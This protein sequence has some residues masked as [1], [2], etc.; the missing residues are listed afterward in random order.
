MV[1]VLWEPEIGKSRKQTQ[2]AH[3]CT[4]ALICYCNTQ[5]FWVLNFQEPNK[6]I[7]QQYKAEKEKL[8][9]IRLLLVSYSLCPYLCRIADVCLI[10]ELLIL[11]LVVL[12]LTI[13][14]V[15]NQLQKK[16]I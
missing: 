3:F 12:I 6:I 16:I 9:K 4:A 7:E 11:C 13:V 14:S 10:L 8:Q 5:L 15:T 2:S 1:V